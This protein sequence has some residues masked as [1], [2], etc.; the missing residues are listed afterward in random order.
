MKKLL[1][2]III[3]LGFT[4]ASYAQKSTGKKVKA[5]AKAKPTKK[6]VTKTGKKI[7]N[8]RPAKWLKDGV[9]SDIN[10]AKSEKKKM[11]RDIA[12]AKQRQAERKKAKAKKKKSKK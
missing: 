4:T 3:I 9:K 8:S 10:N 6:K 2:P 11:D 12:L 1:L 5:A 7:A